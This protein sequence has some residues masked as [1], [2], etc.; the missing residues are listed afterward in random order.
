MGIRRILRPVGHECEF[1][2]VGERFRNPPWGLNGGENGGT[3]RF[4]MVSANGEET[5]LPGKTGDRV[6]QPG[7][8]VLMDSPGAGGWGKAETA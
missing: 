5:P 4:A 2:G 3:G 1:N 6:V 7:G 8:A